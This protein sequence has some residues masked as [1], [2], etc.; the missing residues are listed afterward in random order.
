MPSTRQPSPSCPAPDLPR[1]S[2]C[3]AG[4]L[5][6]DPSVDPDGELDGE[7]DGR[8]GGRQLCFE[9]GPADA[10]RRLDQTLVRAL[11]ADPALA[12]AWSREAVKKAV[13]E[14][15]CRVDGRPQDSPSAKVR[16][17]A[18]IEFAPGPGRDA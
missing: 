5:T 7:L 15:R 12:G 10:G 3:E 9:A 18:R 11:E 8:A 2:A 17:G 16:Q 1:P 13:R 14:G 4:D 6:G